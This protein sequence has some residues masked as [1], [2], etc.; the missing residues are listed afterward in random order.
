[1]NGQMNERMNAPLPFHSGLGSRRIGCGSALALTLGDLDPVPVPLRA[2][3]SVKKRQSHSPSCQPVSIHRGFGQSVSGC[4]HSVP[5]SGAKEL[6]Q[7]PG[8][9]VLLGSSAADWHL[10]A[11]PRRGPGRTLAAAVPRAG[12]EWTQSPVWLSHLCSPLETSAWKTQRPLVQPPP[13]IVQAGPCS[14][15]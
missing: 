9:W 3:F 13:P 1:M 5:V 2:S 12:I 11:G 4:V 7:G 10:A 14:F 6:A 15:Q 8:P